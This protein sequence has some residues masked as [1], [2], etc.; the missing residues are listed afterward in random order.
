[1]SIECGYEFSI[2]L[3]AIISV[4]SEKIFIKKLQTASLTAFT[5]SEE[6]DRINNAVTK[7]ATRLPVV[8]IRVK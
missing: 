6:N 7:Q 3:S 8:H 5:L 4:W 1:S 2:S